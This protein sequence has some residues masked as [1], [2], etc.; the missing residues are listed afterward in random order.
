[1][2]RYE[3]TYQADTNKYSEAYKSYLKDTAHGRLAINRVFFSGFA[4]II[5]FS[6]A[7][8]SF[9]RVGNGDILAYFV[10]VLIALGWFFI[11]RIFIKNNVLGYL[12]KLFANYETYTIKVSVDDVGI[13]SDSFSAKRCLKWPMIEYISK[14]KQV[15]LIKGMLHELLIPLYAFESNEQYQDFFQMISQKLNE[16]KSKVKPDAYQST[17]RIAFDLRIV[18]IFMGLVGLFVI[19]LLF[20]S[21]YTPSEAKRDETDQV[22][23][24]VL[25]NVD[26]FWKEALTDHDLDYLYSMHTTWN[27]QDEVSLDDLKDA[28]GSIQDCVGEFRATELVHYVYSPDPNEVSYVIITIGERSDYADVTLRIRGSEGQCMIRCFMEDWS[29]W[30]LAGF[31]LIE[32]VDIEFKVTPFVP[33]DVR[34]LFSEDSIAGQKLIEDAELSYLLDLL[35]QPKALLNHGAD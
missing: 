17:R 33:D 12:R 16:A 14:T 3:L 23:K 1:M 28:V 2:E 9:V 5:I 35:Y 27:F 24:Q 10:Y 22:Q 34:G 19:F 30:Q 11:G 20:N 7:V 8:S 26:R 4:Y 21:E 29:D 32:L 25:N 15:I 31:E 6:I 18:S 13:E